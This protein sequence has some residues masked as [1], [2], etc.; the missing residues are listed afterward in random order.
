[1]TATATT[2]EPVSTMFRALA[3]RTRLRILHLLRLDGGEICVGDIV[4]I[5]RLPQPKV[6]RHLSYLRRAGILEVR[7]RGLWKLYRLAPARTAFHRKL[8]ECLDASVPGIP[9]LER[10]RA[11]A[12][13][14]SE[15]CCP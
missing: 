15:R 10:D 6:S 9:E 4:S 3:D 1:M 14:L 12:K 2:T 11:R 5:L 8:L 13:T 7:E